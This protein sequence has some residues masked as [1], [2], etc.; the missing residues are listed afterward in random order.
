M[1]QFM[2][3]VKKEWMEQLRTGRFLLLLIVF[4]LFGILSPA[5]AKLTPLL[6]EMM[7]E[8]MQEQG[9]VLQSVTVTALTSWQQF[10][11]NIS[12]M[13]LVLVAMSSGVLT[14]EYQKGTLIIVLTRG[15]PRWMVIAGKMLVQMVCWTIYYWSAFGITLA[16]TVYFWDNGIAKHWLFAGFGIYLVGLWLLGLLMLGSVLL[17]NN[18]G[19]MLFTGAVVMV[20][21]LA[22]MVPD[23]AGWLPTRLLA[24]GTLL[25][26][27]VKMDE[28]A[29]AA[30]VCAGTGVLCVGLAAA[31][32]NKKR[33]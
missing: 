24:S 29:K 4:L 15:L 32:F 11:K 19:V 20:C 1:R 22:G 10:Y 9:L 2:A 26:G 27:V 13:L 14:G 30:W 8:S 23:I 7:Q 21:Y 33:L 5:L 31:G 3:F 17:R 12:M 25:N 16:Y 28:F 6:Y 18:M